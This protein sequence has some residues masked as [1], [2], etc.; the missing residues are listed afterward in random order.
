MLGFEVGG[1]G[2]RAKGR[3]VARRLGRAGLRAGG[4][5][6]GSTR[7]A[8]PSWPAKL[9]TGGRILIVV[10]RLTGAGAGRAIARVARNGVRSGSGRDDVVAAGSQAAATAARSTAAFAPHRA[11]ARKL[12]CEACGIDYPEPEPQLFNF[13]RPLGACPECEGFGNV[14]ATDMDRV[15]PDPSKSI[16]A[17]AIAPWNTPAYAHELRRAAGVGRGLPAA[18]RRAVFGADRGRAAD[19][20]EGVPERDFGGL[21]GFFRWL[22]RRKYKMHLRVFLSRWRS[23]Y[24]VPGMSAAP[25]CGPRRWRFASADRISPT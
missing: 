13:N 16:R 6:Q 17:G 19:R 9:K 11:S 8:E 3:R 18:G 15:V 14:V 1:A 23:Y 21:R 7:D 20:R 22:E 10:D 24:P 25:G 2:R 4:R 5:R 12:R